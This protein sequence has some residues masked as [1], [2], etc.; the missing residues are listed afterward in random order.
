MYLAD[1]LPAV[2]R[3]EVE[4]TL[5]NDGSWRAELERLRAAHEAVSSAL[6]EAEAAPAAAES[7]A[8]RRA[9]GNVVAVMREYQGAWAESYQSRRLPAAGRRR[10]ALTSLRRVFSAV[11]R[12]SVGAAAAA[13]ALALGLSFYF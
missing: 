13:V 8:A 1:E 6:G 7:A 2:D 11:P 4:Q 9:V 10:G 12:S 5:A 3:V